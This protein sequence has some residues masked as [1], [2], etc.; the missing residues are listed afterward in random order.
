MKKINLV[1][2]GLLSNSNIFSFGN[3]VYF[4]IKKNKVKIILATLDTS[5]NTIKKLKNLIKNKNI[6][7]VLIENNSKEIGEAIGK[8]KVKIIGLN[9]EK[10]KEKLII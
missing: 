1:F 2:L 5:E 6:D 7:L 10:V 9:D 4:D 8:E 3:D